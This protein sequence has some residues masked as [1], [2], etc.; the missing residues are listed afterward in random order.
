MAQR[1]FKQIYKPPFYYDPEG[2][3]IFDQEGQML[4][5]R[6]WGRLT[7]NR[8]KLQTDQAMKIQD[9]LGD[10]VADLMNKNWPSE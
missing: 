3:M 8:Y 7:G 4:D 9:N 10:W 6:S 5:V 1:D 2:Q